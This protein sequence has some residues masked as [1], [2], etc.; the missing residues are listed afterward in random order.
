MKKIILILSLVSIMA[1]AGAQEIKWMKIEEAVA[2]AQKT[3]KKIFI[4]VYTDWCGWC[5][6]MDQTTFSNPVIANYINEN[7]YAVKLDAETTDTITFKGYQF[8]YK[9]GPDGRGGMNYF[10]Y[11]LLNGKTS[12]PSYVIMNEQQNLLTVLRGYQDAE[13]FEPLLHFFAEDAYKT[14]EWETYR[15]DFKSELK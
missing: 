9:S 3:P 10:A 15:A 6:R 13:R 5:R 1:S 4:D 11:A 14:T 2:A 8:T 7:Y 12:F